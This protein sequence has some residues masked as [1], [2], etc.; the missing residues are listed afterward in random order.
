MA[1]KEAAGALAEADDENAA[2]LQEHDKP[3]ASIP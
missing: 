3:F 2:V 1:G